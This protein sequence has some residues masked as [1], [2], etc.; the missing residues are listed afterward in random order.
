MAVK[1]QAYHLSQNITLIESTVQV[2]IA[3]Y[4]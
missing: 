4:E 2:D 1:N 3:N